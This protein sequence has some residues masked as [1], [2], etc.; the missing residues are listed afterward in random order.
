MKGYESQGSTLAKN[1][2]FSQEAAALE[3]ATPRERQ[4]TNSSS[5]AGLVH[6][7]TIHQLTHHI[8]HS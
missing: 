8:P 2:A 4:Q 3:G 6:N 7:A 1:Q 5:G